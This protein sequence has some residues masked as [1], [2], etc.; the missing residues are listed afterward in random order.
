MS[1]RRRLVLPLSL[2][3]L[4][5]TGSA[6][7]QF[8]V[9]PDP[10][11]DLRI[12]EIQV[13]GSHNSYKIQ[14]SD[15]LQAAIQFV[16]DNLPP[17]SG[18]PD[19]G[20][21]VYTHRPLA[22]QFGD[23]GI[24][25]IELDVWVDRL[26]GTF[27]VPFGPAA[28]MAL[29][30]AAGPDFDPGDIMLGPGIKVFHIQD[31]DFRSHCPL[32]LQCLEEIKAW[33]DANP[34]HLPILILVELKEEVPDVDLS[35]L[36]LAFAIPTPWALQDLQELEDNIRTVFHDTRLIQPNDVRAGY[37]TLFEGIQAEGWPRV[38]DARGKV[39][40][41]L[42][43]E[44]AQRDIYV[45]HYPGLDGAVI[46][47]SSPTGSP[48]A[49]FRK[50]NN[51]FR[52]GPSIEELVQAGYMVRTRADA[53]TVEARANDTGRR[54]AA[55]ASGAQFVSTDYREPNPAFIPPSDYQV[56]L[57]GLPPGAVAR[58]NPASTL[59]TCASDLIEP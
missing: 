30:Q 38:S 33:S 28:A 56:Q 44:G 34:D 40:F 50:E 45:G 6:C 32:F 13:V 31:I 29:G 36:G 48:E 35:A 47:T 14:P 21:L 24:R 42:D 16:Y 53:D 2:A 25:Q 4:V 23:L 17:N 27:A 15:G 7:R 3:L 12:N 57:P 1:N 55:L 19:P 51:P 9:P 59:A 54:D 58:C 26:G 43:N 46:F 20:G 18:V 41:A 22:E 52:T 10:L 49:G 11:E 5:A 37:P 8:D 39:F